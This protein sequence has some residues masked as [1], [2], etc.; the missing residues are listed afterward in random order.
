MFENAPT[1]DTVRITIKQ[2]RSNPVLRS[3]SLYEKVATD[4]QE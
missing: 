3:I 2:S 4:T 1:T